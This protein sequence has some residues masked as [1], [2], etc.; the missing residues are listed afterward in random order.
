MDIPIKYYSFRGTRIIKNRCS[1]HSYLLD[2][3]FYGSVLFVNLLTEANWLITFLTFF[4]FFLLAY[5][6]LVLQPGMEPMP[7]AVETWSPNLWTARESLNRI[8]FRSWYRKYARH[9]CKDSGRA[10]NLTLPKRLSFSISTLTENLWILQTLICQ[11]FNT[12]FKALR[13]TLSHRPFMAI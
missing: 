10:L 12:V 5:R 13:Y 3:T 8:Y 9:V 2:C 11:S 6:I 7:P 1:Q 4:F